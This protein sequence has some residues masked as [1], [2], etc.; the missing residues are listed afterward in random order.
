MLKSDWNNHLFTSNL[1]KVLGYLFVSALF[2]FDSY[3]TLHFG[4][5]LG[6][7]FVGVGETLLVLLTRRDPSERIGSIL[8]RP[9]RR[10]K[11]AS[12]SPRVR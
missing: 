12:S 1:Y 3:R 2:L 11:A 10:R 7:A 5:V 6:A 8:L 4:I 9:R